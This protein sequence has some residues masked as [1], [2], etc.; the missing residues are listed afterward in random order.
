[1]KVITVG[2]EKGGVGK[3]TIA[4]NLAVMAA[5]DGKSVLLVDADSQESAMNFRTLRKAEQ[6]LDDIQAISMAKSEAIFE[7]V[8]KFANFDL[9]IIDTGGRDTVTF[10][11]AIL[12]ANGGIFLIPV[13]LGQYDIWSTRNTL[14]ILKQMRAVGVKIN[15]AFVVNQELTSHT[16]LTV[17]AKEALRQL[18]EEFNVEIMDNVLFNRVDYSKAVTLGQGVGEFKAKS[19]AAA[20]V[21]AL[22]AETMTKLEG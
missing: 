9:V 14:D 15:A 19:K 7:D 17:E 3:S 21:A 4:C 18:A 22:Y 2:N 12:A 13:K 16:T 5:R 20:E 6:K 1:M 8:K 10:R 11:S